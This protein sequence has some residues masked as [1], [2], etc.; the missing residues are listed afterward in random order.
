MSP[1]RKM[2]RKKRK[3][4]KTQK[5]GGDRFTDK[6][7]ENFLKNVKGSTTKQNK[8]NKLGSENKIYDFY[9]SKTKIND[10]GGILPTNVENHTYSSYFNGT[11][12]DSDRMEWNEY[13]DALVN[14]LQEYNKPPKNLEVQNVVN[15][16]QMLNQISMWDKFRSIFIPDNTANYTDPR[17]HYI[18]ETDI[19]MTTLPNP[20]GF[21]MDPTSDVLHNTQFEVIEKFPGGPLDRMLHAFYNVENDLYL[22]M[23]LGDGKPASADK[24]K[25]IMDAN[26]KSQ[27]DV[28]KFANS[29]PIIKKG[30]D[31]TPPTA[32]IKLKST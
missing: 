21:A 24:L 31:V 8:E 14:A 17:K 16:L 6:Q 20:L 2:K 30:I 29:N 11:F 19:I 25:R 28:F 26:K 12:P 5:G 4:R 10:D 22:K 15:I 32:Q 27:K 1:T 3:S 7:L 9:Y 18:K 23:L 13:I